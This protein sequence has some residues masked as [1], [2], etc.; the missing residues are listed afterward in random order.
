M[1]EISWTTSS[2][3]LRMVAGDTPKYEGVADQSDHLYGF[4]QMTNPIPFL[5]LLTFGITNSCNFL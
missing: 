4:G 1:A 3:R 2:D 5:G